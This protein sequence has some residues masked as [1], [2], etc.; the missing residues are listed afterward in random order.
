[1]ERVTMNE[2]LQNGHQ[3]SSV[4][5]NFT[6]KLEIRRAPRDIGM[7]ATAE[8]GVG[9]GWRRCPRLRTRLESPNDGCEER[10]RVKV[11]Y[12]NREG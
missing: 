10:A 6:T 12:G 4:A 1:M 7:L 8:H 9:E 11:T 2:T 3:R 5:R